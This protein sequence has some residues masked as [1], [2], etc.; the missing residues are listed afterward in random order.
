MPRVEFKSENKVATT[1]Y[2]YP[3][4]KL[5][6]GERARI[7]VG[8]E[9]PIVEYVHTLRKPQIINGVPQTIKAERKDG[10][11]YD[12]YKM[13][14]I[15]RPICLG[16]ATTLADKGSDPKN[17]PMCKL[18]QEHSDYTSAPQRRYAMHVIRY[19]TKPGD[20]QELSTPFSV[21]VLVWSYTDKTF[22]KIVDFR[23]EWGDLRKHDLLL[24]PCTNETFQQFD[25]T[26]AAKAAWL[27]DDERKRLTAQTFKENLIPDLTI[28]AG[29]VKQK[30]WVEQDIQSILEAWGQVHGA[31]SGA[32]ATGLDEDL[33]GLL[34]GDDEKWADGKSE[35]DRQREFAASQETTTPEDDE[36]LLA[37]LDEFAGNTTS[38]PEVAEEPEAEEEPAAPP[39]KKSSAKSK[40]APEEAP[41]VAEE[42]VDNF[43]DLLADL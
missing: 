22:N 21:D 29:S 23:E 6:S 11:T 24:G 20:K 10:S 19:R 42:G 16:D 26:V 36:D 41:A 25:I 2:D 37:G 34:G 14:F 28:A 18:A 32:D 8:L 15:S 13:D 31:Q 1:S 43:D 3:K 27:E 33:N 40:P 9:D 12:D 38:N 7:I 4:L 35:A 17:C 30:Q 39:A 5:K